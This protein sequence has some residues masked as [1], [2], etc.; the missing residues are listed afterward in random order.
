LLTP[1]GKIDLTFPN[2]V[3][4]K[5]YTNRIKFMHFQITYIV[6]GNIGFN[7]LVAV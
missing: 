3:K 2:H 7:L 4:D 1:K 5:S 6:I